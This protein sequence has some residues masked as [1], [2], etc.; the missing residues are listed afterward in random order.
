[1]NVSFASK[2]TKKVDIQYCTG[3]TSSM[4]EPE[5]LQTFAT[6][7][8]GIEPLHGKQYFEA[9]RL[10]SSAT[11]RI[12]I[13]YLQGITTDMQ[14]K[15]GTKTYEIDSIIDINERHREMH[16]MCREVI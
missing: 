7:Y 6:V 5:T 2:L 13:R 16:L 1:M 11:I 14:V 8:A 9:N 15:Y 3:A 12:Y 4:T 10:D